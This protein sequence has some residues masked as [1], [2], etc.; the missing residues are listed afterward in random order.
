VRVH[1][2]IAIA[3]ALG[4]L[5]CGPAAPAAGSRDPA[6]PVEAR[7]AAKRNELA[8]GRPVRP[9]ARSRRVSRDPA[10]PSV[11]ADPRPPAEAAPRVE[12]VGDSEP[13]IQPLSDHLSRRERLT[14]ACHRDTF[15]AA[16]PSQLRF[17][18]PREREFC[19]CMVDTVISTRV[20]ASLQDALIEDFKANRERVEAA[21]PEFNR[22]WHRC[23]M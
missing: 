3:L 20:A 10:A 1:G 2:L 17:L 7:L 9:P 4:L 16:D 11:P 19:R 23:R 14:R 12:P 21:N 6:S 13:A 18:L 8:E 5:G 15:G 22:R